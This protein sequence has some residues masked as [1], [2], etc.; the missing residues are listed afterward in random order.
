MRFVQAPPRLLR[1]CSATARV[2]GYAVPCPMKIPKGLGLGGVIGPAEG[3]WRG[4]AVGSTAVG[5]HHLVM[6][7]SPR[8]LRDYAKVVNG[9]AW[10]RGQRVDPIAWV[11]IR[12]VRMRA[13]F[14]PP[15]T[16]DGSAFMHH[17]VLIWTAGGHTYGVGFHAVGSIE[18]TLLLDVA[19]ARHIRLVRG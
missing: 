18:Q 9:P 14:V 8:P 11:R 7:A 4:W 6:T 15:A 1:E 5:V 2:V 17:V 19:L 13:V 12:G 10:Y 3:S 16:N